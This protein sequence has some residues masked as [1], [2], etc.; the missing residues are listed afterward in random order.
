[1]WLFSKMFTAS[2]G[3]GGTLPGAWAYHIAEVWQGGI[4]YWDGMSWDVKG[5]EQ[6]GYMIYIWSIY[7]LYMIYI[8]SSLY[9]I[10]I[11]S[12]GLMC[13]SHT[14]WKHQKK[15]WDSVGINTYA[16]AHIGMCILTGNDPVVSYWFLLIPWCGHLP[17]S[18]Q[19]QQGLSGCWNVNTSNMM[20]ACGKSGL[21]QTMLC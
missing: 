16:W 20:W 21:K 12:M 4:W 1:M 7:D 14:C 10:Y 5:F 3:P 18:R 17:T 2:D 15:L 9:M 8:W 11:W 19:C 6:C 13:A